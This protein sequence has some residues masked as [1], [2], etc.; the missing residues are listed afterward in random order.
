MWSDYICD[1]R[2][3]TVVCA[4]DMIGTGERLR[5]FLLIRIGCELPPGATRKPA[6]LGHQRRCRRYFAMGVG[7]SEGLNSTRLGRSWGSAWGQN[8]KQPISNRASAQRPKAVIPPN[9]ST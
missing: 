3:G 4:R 5:F 9:Y 1:V 6:R 2:A 7:F 8:R